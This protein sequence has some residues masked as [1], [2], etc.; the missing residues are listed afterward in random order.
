[1]ALELNV[2][3]PHGF[4]AS[5]WM[6][7]MIQIHWT[8]RKADIFVAGY[9][10]IDCKTAGKL[11]VTKRYHWTGDDFPFSNGVESVSEVVYTKLK[12]LEEWV[13]SRDV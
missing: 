1:M 12:T 6:V 10:D 7:S 3:T 2:E 8:E 5:Y 4:V 9:K 13:G 11:C